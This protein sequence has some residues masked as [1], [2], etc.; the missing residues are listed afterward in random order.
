MSKQQDLF[1]NK[2]AALVKEF[3]KV[4]SEH[5]LRLKVRDAFFDDYSVEM[6][7]VS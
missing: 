1:Q 6:P 2:A 3:T 5:D 7:P 4:K